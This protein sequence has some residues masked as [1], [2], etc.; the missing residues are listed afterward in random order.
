M[1]RHQEETAARQVDVHRNIDKRST[2]AFQGSPVG[3]L[4]PAA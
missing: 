4:G 1:L 3:A 2:P